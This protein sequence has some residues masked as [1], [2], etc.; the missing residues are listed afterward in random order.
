MKL[1]RKIFLYIFKYT[2]LFSLLFSITGC[3]TLDTFD[4]AFKDGAIVF[5]PAGKFKGKAFKVSSFQVIR[6]NCTLDCIVWDIE[7]KISESGDIETNNIE[8]LTSLVFGQPV[9]GV[10]TVVMAKPLVDGNYKAG[11]KI[12]Y[13]GIKKEKRASLLTLKF[14]INNGQVS[15][16]GDDSD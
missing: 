3:K 10:N 9:S 5:S 2:A 1:P 16:T 6:D 4:V 7:I 15:I 14:R 12:I 13:T 11:G 8:E